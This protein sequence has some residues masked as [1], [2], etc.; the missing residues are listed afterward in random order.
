[1]G[2]SE[3]M[4]ALSDPVRRQILELLKDGKKSA[5]D[6][7]SE[8]DLTNA[9]VSYHLSQLKKAQLIVESKFKNFVY[10]ELNVSVF[11][12]V[13]LWIYQFGGNNNEKI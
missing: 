9:T 4:K 1:M 3:T 6:I 10:Y 7:A 11:E 5:G 13:M 2:M 8:F 12:E